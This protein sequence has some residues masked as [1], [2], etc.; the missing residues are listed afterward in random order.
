MILVSRSRRGTTKPLP[1]KGCATARRGYASATVAVDRV[2]DGAAQRGQWGIG[3][4]QKRGNGIRRDRQ[5]ELGRCGGR[6]AVD[7]DG[8]GPAALNPIHMRAAADRI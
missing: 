4:F 6:H 3:R 2:R 8:V 5:D 1:F 7:V